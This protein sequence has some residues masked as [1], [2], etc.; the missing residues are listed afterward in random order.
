MACSRATKARSGAKWPGSM[1]SKASSGS[2]GRDRG[3]ARRGQ[4]P[5]RRDRGTPRR[6]RGP[7]VGIEGLEGVIG[8][9]RAGSSVSRVK[10]R[11]SKASG[12]AAHT[13]S[14]WAAK[15]R[16]AIL[17]SGVGK[18]TRV[19][20]TLAA[21]PAREGRDVIGRALRVLRHIYP[22]QVST[23]A[24]FCFSPYCKFLSYFMKIFQK[25]LPNLRKIA[26]ILLTFVLLYVVHRT[27]NVIG[28]LHMVPY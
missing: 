11:A 22:W 16:D 3:S 2:A 27:F 9:R 13:C 6:D 17:N 23:P 25:I 15:E 28:L 14:V 4:G 20:P 5:A 10:S 7:G 26:P 12:L 24:P 18:E 19:A 8:V 1:V 21:P